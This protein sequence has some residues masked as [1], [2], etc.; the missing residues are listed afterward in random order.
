MCLL[1]VSVVSFS[2]QAEVQLQAQQQP[3]ATLEAL[4][5]VMQ[6][7]APRTHSCMSCQ[8]P[9]AVHGRLVPCKHAFCLECATEMPK[10]VIC[11]SNIQVV[12]RV[13]Q[14][15]Y[16]SPLSHRTYFTE[17]ELQLDTRQMFRRIGLVPALAEAYQQYHQQRQSQSGGL[18][19]A[20]MAMQQQA[21]G[22]QQLQQRVSGQ[23]QMRPPQQ[24]QSQQHSN[25]M[26][27][28]QQ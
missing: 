19:A 13:P 28:T 18:P 6:V 20:P 16:V 25:S 1:A 15:L 2:M 27:R 26:Q 14:A 11:C 8:V 22:K 17:E 9:I 24:Q 21:Q 7:P 10:C 23:Q 5:T 12:E 3:S 4:G